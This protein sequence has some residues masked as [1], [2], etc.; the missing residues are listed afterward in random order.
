MFIAQRITDLILIQQ[1]NPIHFIT[2][3][4]NLPWEEITL[5]VHVPRSEFHNFTMVYTMHSLIS[6]VT[7]QVNEYAMYSGAHYL[8]VT[9]LVA[10]FSDMNTVAVVL[11]YMFF[12][13]VIFW[14]I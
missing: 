7:G 12:H 3:S 1:E 8:S 5:F 4:D 9:A 2:H 13:L 11:L 10:E 14:H 6:I